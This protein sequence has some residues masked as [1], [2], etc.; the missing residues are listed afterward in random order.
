M[1]TVL[2]K[3]PSHANSQTTS[4]TTK[5]IYKNNI[6]KKVKTGNDVSHHL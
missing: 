1:L 2:L 3:R 4:T 5:Y 6:D